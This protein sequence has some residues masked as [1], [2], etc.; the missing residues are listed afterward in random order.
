MYSRL[1]KIGIDKNL[2]GKCYL[3]KA[4]DFIH[5]D[6][7]KYTGGLLVTKGEN[8]RSDLIEHGYNVDG[9]G[10]TDLID[11]LDTG[12][13]LIETKNNSDTL[14]EFMNSLKDV[15]NQDELKN[16]IEVELVRRVDNKRSS[17]KRKYK[18]MIKLFCVIDC[19]FMECKDT[20]EYYQFIDISG[21]SIRNARIITK[22]SKQLNLDR[23]NY[24]VFIDSSID[25]AE[26]KVI[27]FRD[28]NTIIPADIDT[29]ESI[30][31]T[32]TK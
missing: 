22:L 7:I 15:I 17:I 10:C 12:I 5:P 20:I 18:G 6:N 32:I 14:N 4:L 23:S 11:I 13:L 8:L 31:E 25:T 26:S 9:C 29:M 28:K 16:R 1:N 27:S 2:F 3:D 21:M 24:S 19:S 30:P